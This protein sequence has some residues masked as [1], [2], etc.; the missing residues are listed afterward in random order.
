VEVIALA[1]IGAVAGCTGLA[2]L[3]QGQAAFSALVLG[4]GAMFGAGLVGFTAEYWFDWSGRS[5]G[6][7]QVFIGYFLFGG[8]AWLGALVLAVSAAIVVAIRPKQKVPSI[9]QNPE[10]KP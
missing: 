1:L 6:D 9:G 3:W 7:G 4:I 10:R 2:R 8:A 5:R